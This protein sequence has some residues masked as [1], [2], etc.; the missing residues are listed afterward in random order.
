MKCWGDGSYGE[1]GDGT[2]VSSSVPVDVSGL[3]SGVAAISTSLG[4]NSACAL[5]SGGGVKCWGDTSLYIFSQSTSTKSSV[6]LA[7]TGL[8][9]GIASVSVGTF[10]ACVL[11]TGGGVRCW[12][13][14]SNGELGNGTTGPYYT[15]P[16][17]T[18]ASYTPIVVNVTG[19]SSG[20]VSV[21]AGRDFTCALTAAG[22]VQCW[23]NNSRG[24][25]GDGT[26]TSS[27][28]PVTVSGLSSGVIAMSIPASTASRVASALPC[29]R[30]R[31]PSLPPSSP[32][33]EAQKIM[34]GSAHHN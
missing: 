32:M 10:H 25:L 23:G 31:T 12:G 28:L 20:V 7:V 34:L 13:N 8:E 33:P 30:T 14:G 22:G 3:T 4:Q 5:T 29:C 6:P 26:T 9:S 2:T 1:L 19:L 18:A 15:V 27:S 21:S 17:G 16:D 11:T 24:Q